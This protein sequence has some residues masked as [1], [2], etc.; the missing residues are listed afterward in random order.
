[1]VH[2]VIRRSNSHF[3]LCE[4]VLSMVIAVPFG[5]DSHATC[6]RSISNHDITILAI[7]LWLY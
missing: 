1:M 3:A 7:N 5:A 4:Q 6:E 2:R